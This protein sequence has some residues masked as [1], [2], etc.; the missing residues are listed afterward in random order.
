[1]RNLSL[2]LSSLL[3]GAIVFPVS[4]QARQSHDLSNALLLAQD[5]IDRCYENKELNQCDKVSQI[6]TTLSNWCS[7]GDE[8]ACVTYTTVMYLEQ[9]AAS[10]QI[11]DQ[12]IR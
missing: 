12:I 2:L 11:T 1:M 7:G 5:A 4:V 8:G 10:K 3:V 9:S 6:Q